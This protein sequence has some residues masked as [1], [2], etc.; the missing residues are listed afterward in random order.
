MALRA[1]LLR[2]QIDDKKKALEELRAK[3][4]EFSRREAE[5][6]ASI[7]EAES[8]EDRKAVADLVN[9]F[10]QDKTAHEAEKTTLNGEIEQLER[11]L[12]TEE[13]K[14]PPPE[15]GGPA[16]PQKKND[17]AGGERKDMN[18]V[19]MK[20][21]GFLNMD[22][23]SRDAFLAR[24]DVK[25]FL[26]RV[27]QLGMEKRAA[28]GAEL[29]IPDVMLDLL[30]ENISK[31]SKMIAH[32]NLRPLSGTAR[33]NI[34]GT[35]P[36]AVWTEACAKL[37]ELELV[38][39]QVEV[40]G[41]KVG[42]YIPI[43]NAT[44][45]DSDL[46]LASEILDALGQAI[47]YAVDKAVIYGTGVKMPLGV[48]TRLAQTVQPADW[49]ANAP[50]W[51]KLSQSNIQTITGK[52]GKDLFKQI[53]LTAG[54]A[55]NS[56][57]TGPI[58]WVMNETTKNQLVAEGLEF[59]SAA[60]IVSGI[61]NT[62]PVV[63]GDIVTLDFIPDGDIVFGYFALYLLVQRAGAKLAQSEHV[64]FL[65][66]QTVFKGTARYDGEPVIGEAFGVVNIGGTSPTTSATFAPDT[67]NP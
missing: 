50:A 15:G 7:N 38:F 1:L 3:D 58:T 40:D 54:V 67:A 12:A 48:V 43:C 11:D 53:V 36:E 28:T 59:N 24:Q 56:Y 34:M 25:D 10:D 44:L 27:R 5:L 42:G 14:N 9:E 52:T 65:D 49:P 55:R 62:M 32:I 51:K 61:N 47:G 13:A 23:R 33:Q 2:K 37:N 41:Y 26:Q 6:E 20:T 4:P 46:N 17:A 29:T 22:V 63:G 21:R 16:E 60:A 18:I 30:R 66:D 39:N 31:Y 64:R 45:E 35:I 19:S 57:A 8:E